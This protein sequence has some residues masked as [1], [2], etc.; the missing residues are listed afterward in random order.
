[1]VDDGLATGYTARAAVVSCRRAG[2]ARIVVAVPVGAEET[3]AQMRADGI[4]VVC[5]HAPA[6]F[7]AV[8]EWYDDFGQTSD[9]EVIELMSRAHRPGA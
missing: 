4:E 6:W 8:G 7:M 9:R 5:L 3:V 2:A 1:M